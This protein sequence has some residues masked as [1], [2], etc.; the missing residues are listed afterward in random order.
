MTTTLAPPRPEAKEPPPPPVEPRRLPRWAW[1]FVV[2]GVWIV[3]WAF[4]E[5]QDTLVLAQPDWGWYPR[6]DEGDR[7]SVHVFSLESDA[8]SYVGSGFVPGATVLPMPTPRLDSAEASRT[9]R[10]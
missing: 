4:T 8:T 10:S 2:L 3:V 7:T 9:Q 5:G 6:G 1:A